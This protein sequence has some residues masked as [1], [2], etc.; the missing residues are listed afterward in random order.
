MGSRSANATTWAILKKPRYRP[1]YAE[2]DY[3]VASDTFK[4]L[5]SGTDCGHACHTIVKAKDYVFTAFPKR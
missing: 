4:P 3:D 1:F 5:G 2:F